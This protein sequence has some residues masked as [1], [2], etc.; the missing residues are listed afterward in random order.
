MDLPTCPSCGQSVLDEN[1]E[2]CP[3]CGSSMTA[4]PGQKPAP[5]PKKGGA[6]PSPKAAKPSPGA[7]PA[8]PQKKAAEK[9]KE[10]DPFAFKTEVQDASVRVALKPAKGRTYEVTCPMCETTG[11]IPESAAG[12]NVRCA[13]PSCMVP[14]FEAPAIKVEEKPVEKPKRKVN[15]AVL[16]V[17]VVFLGIVGFNVWWFVF[18]TPEEVDTLKFAPLADQDQNDN[19]ASNPDKDKNENETEQQQPVAPV[20]DA[21][22]F[23]DR[24]LDIVMLDIAQ[25][26]ERN[27]E[28]NRS[29]EFCRQLLTECY[30]R[31]GMIEKARRQ[32][33]LID[34][35][36]EQYFYQRLSPLVEILWHEL[37]SKSASELNETL[38]D[39]QKAAAG[40]AS[41]GRGRFDRFTGLAAILVVADRADE[42]RQLVRKAW[43]DANVSDERELM[44]LR[45][46]SS[47]LRVLRD[48]PDAPYPLDIENPLVRREY[49]EWVTVTMLLAGHNRTALAAD[50]IRSSR[51][52]RVRSDCLAALCRWGTAS[53]RYPLKELEAI[54]SEQP[55]VTKARVFAAASTELRRAENPSDADRL[56]KAAEQAAAGI[57]AA[58]EFLLPEPAR[59]LTLSPADPR[60]KVHGVLALATLAESQ[61]YAGNDDAAWTSV[62]RA[63][64]LCRALG[65]S[66]VV[67]S[68]QPRRS[69]DSGANAIMSQLESA[70]SLTNRNAILREF[71]NFTSKLNEFEPLADER[72][73]L[74]TEILGN[75]L[76]W[77]MAS[78]VWAEMRARIDESDPAKKEPFLQSPLIGR[79]RRGLQEAKDTKGLDELKLRL[80]G[81]MPTVDPLD[82]FENALTAMEQ[83]GNFDGYEAA[84]QQWSPNRNRLEVLLLNRSQKLAAAG[85]L[86]V[87]AELL[88]SLPNSMKVR[89]VSKNLVNID[90]STLRE[91]LYFFLGR[92]AS[93]DGKPQEMNALIPDLLPTPTE[94]ASIL[95]GIVLGLDTTPPEKTEPETDKSAKE[96]PAP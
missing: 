21:V 3:F 38:E 40:S 69:S 61:H 6:K 73:Q 48:L 66:L 67:M 68:Q 91:E 32:L 56:L 27:G 13:N 87:G 90:L 78:R 16:I 58:E 9:K 84:L 7:S 80:G 45:Q 2:T 17:G 63:L 47:F 71:N 19:G 88:D 54:T 20:F 64:A 65:P 96:K 75:A 29:P 77:K 51:D 34:R 23:R 82:A 42:A 11:Y 70:L 59:V 83:T 28:R 37:D 15:P 25:S 35:G 89:D 26:R 43:D 24:L 18:R 46:T 30:A 33:P 95:A 93:A 72:S 55:D 39:A 76:K 86:E 85:R 50:W 8:A 94:E 44:L 22:K 10:E 92:T 31:L 41:V 60:G 14:V 81:Q 5:A 49:P 53:G 62:G 12:K 57:G 4:K 1:P 79:V 36:R 52:E 74:T